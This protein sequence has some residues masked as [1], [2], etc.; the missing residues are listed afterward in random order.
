MSIVDEEEKVS[1]SKIQVTRHQRR[2]KMLVKSVPSTKWS[3]ARSR[4]S[5]RLSMSDE[6]HFAQSLR[7]TEATGASK[8]WIQREERTYP[9]FIVKFS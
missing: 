4:P 3:S 2:N 7:Q 9:Q 5:A 6:T 1:N 8:Q